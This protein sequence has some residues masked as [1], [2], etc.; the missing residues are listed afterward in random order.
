MESDSKGKND[1]I[2]DPMCPLCTFTLWKCWVCC[3]SVQQNQY[4]SQSARESET[5]LFLNAQGRSFCKHTNMKLLFKLFFRFPR[6]YVMF[7]FILL[8]ST[9]K[10][11]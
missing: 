4:V 8:F 9:S 11:A 3:T 10:G 1:I 6:F 5:G 2:F 7:H